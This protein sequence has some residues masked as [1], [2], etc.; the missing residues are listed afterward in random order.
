MESLFTLENLLRLLSLPVVI[1]FLFNLCK[2]LFFRKIIVRFPDT[3]SNNS[4]DK[5]V[6]NEVIEVSCTSFGKIEV[7]DFRVPIRIHAKAECCI[8]SCEVIDRSGCN[9]KPLIRISNNKKSV[10][11]QPLK[12]VR[13]DRFSIKIKYTGSLYLA[14]LEGKIQDGEIVADSQQSRYKKTS[15]VYLFLNFFFYGFW[16]SIN[17]PAAFG[18]LI[19]NTFVMNIIILLSL[20]SIL[21]WMELHCHKLDE[22]CSK[23]IKV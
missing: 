12:L 2:N 13:G 23:V 7:D 14:E 17:I 20:V 4:S 9:V 6:K 11:I 22:K 3:D 18:V 19:P 10:E 21:L 15:G 16:L 1:Q 8:E 5:L